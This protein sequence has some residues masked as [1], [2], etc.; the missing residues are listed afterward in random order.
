MDDLYKNI[1][2]RREELGMSQAELAKKVGY[3]SRSTIARIERGDFDLSQSKILEIAKALKISAGELM[4]LD[5]IEV[6]IAPAPRE[7][8]FDD[9]TFALINREDIRAFVEVAR[10]ANP[11]DVDRMTDFLKRMTAYYTALKGENH[12]TDKR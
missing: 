6:E 11:A 2:F 9:L 5:G 3:T 12:D 1:K 7:E 10:H 8:G 4:G